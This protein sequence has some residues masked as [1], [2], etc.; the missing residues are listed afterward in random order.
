MRGVISDLKKQKQLLTKVYISSEKKPD[1]GIFCIRASF[2]RSWGVY[3]FA[4][5]DTLTAFFVVKLALLF[6]CNTVMKSHS[7]PPESIDKGKILSLPKI[8]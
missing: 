3:C 7:G 8:D 4:S 5:F 6:Y 1:Q 2:N